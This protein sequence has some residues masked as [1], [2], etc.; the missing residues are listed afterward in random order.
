MVP[1]Y[2]LS[3]GRAAVLPFPHGRSKMCSTDWLG[4]RVVMH[5][6][7]FPFFAVIFVLHSLF[8]PPMFECSD[9]LIEIL[10]K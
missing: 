3:L 10:G 8:L 9:A 2:D 1:F 7:H 4:G 6:H 5:P